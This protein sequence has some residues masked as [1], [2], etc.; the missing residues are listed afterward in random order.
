MVRLQNEHGYIDIASDVFTTLTGDAATNCF[1]VKGMTVRSMTDG[2]VHLLKR[3]FMGKG[4][5]VTYNNDNTISIELHIAVDRGVN[6]PVICE[7]IKH[8]V[9]YKVTS[10]TGVEVKRIDIFVDSMLL[11]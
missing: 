8:Q 3:E 6:I 9:G 2:F 5:H 4:V 10:G 7:S 11:G 1:G